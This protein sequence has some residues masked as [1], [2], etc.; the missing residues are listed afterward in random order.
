MTDAE[1]ASLRRS[2][3]LAENRKREGAVARANQRA[4]AETG[5]LIRF[6]AD[7]RE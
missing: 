4:P 5:A 1:K 6:R 2:K 3:S 7:Q